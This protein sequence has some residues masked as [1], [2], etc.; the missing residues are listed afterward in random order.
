M[1]NLHQNL[2]ETKAP[3]SGVLTLNGVK[4][5]SLIPVLAEFWFIWCPTEHRPKRQHPSLESART[6][7]LRLHR[8]APDKE[9]LIYKAVAI[10]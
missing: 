7:A 8:L 3:H 5:K 4:P 6:E 10:K 9:Y 1:G 2:P